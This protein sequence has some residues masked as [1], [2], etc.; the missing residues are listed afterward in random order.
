MTQTPYTLLIDGY[1]GAGK[2]TL[3]LQIGHALGI[4]VVHMDDFY[5][6]WSGLAEGARIVAHSVLRT[7]NPGYQR[8]DWYQHQPGPWVRLDPQAD[9]IVEGVGAVTAAS[10]R[11]AQL[12]GNVDTLRVELD[13]KTRQQR[14][15]MRDA[16][17]APYWQMWAAQEARLEQVPVDVV[18][19][20]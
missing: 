8:W 16:H 4:P 3:A 9:L 6:G 2:T 15:F 12:R 18:V 13:A 5:P 11:A 14:A 20:G 19:R 17:F 7:V 1:S 10:I